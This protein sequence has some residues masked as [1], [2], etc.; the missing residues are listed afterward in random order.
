MTRPAP[1][2]TRLDVR[3]AHVVARVRQGV[4]VADAAREVWI[5]P[6]TV[7][8]WRERTPGFAERMDQARRDARI[9][10][11]RRQQERFLALVR[12]GLTVA[13]A[14]GRM[15]LGHSQAQNWLKDGRHGCDRWFEHEYR[16]L[17]G[18]TGHTRQR[19]DRL[20]AAL[21]TGAS[22]PRAATAAGLS[23]AC[24]YRWRTRRPDL[25][26]RVTETMAAARAA[27][28]VNED[29]QQEDKAA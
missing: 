13:G 4:P 2:F 24:V 12:G 14:L 9:M 18:P 6:K 5:S 28:L 27:R 21:A 26:A 25:W 3:Q 29:E 8:H 23:S 11:K 19:Y 22:I 7:Q 15:G 16:R 20:F 1:D 10:A 17:L